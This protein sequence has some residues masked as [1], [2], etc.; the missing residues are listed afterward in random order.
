MTAT[1]HSQIR[2]ALL[3]LAD[4]LAHADDVLADYQDEHGDDTKDTPG[5]ATSEQVAAL[6][7]FRV[8]ASEIASQ[9]A[10]ALAAF[11]A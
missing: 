4:A 8:Q 9:I 5:S 7:M 2:S 3:E 10:Q 11:T 6:I 1:T